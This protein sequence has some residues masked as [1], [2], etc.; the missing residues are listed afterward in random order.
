MSVSIELCDGH[1]LVYVSGLESVTAMATDGYFVPLELYAKAMDV[2]ISTANTW[3]RRGNIEG[4]TI[5]GKRYVKKNAP[6]MHTR[7]S[8]FSAKVQI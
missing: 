8:K 1:N 7:W 2:N 4:I 5:F 3:F 6:L